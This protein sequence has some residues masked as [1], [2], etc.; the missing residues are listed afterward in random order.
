MHVSTRH[1]PGLNISPLFQGE[2]WALPT[3]ARKGKEGWFKGK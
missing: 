1:I 3:M 2:A